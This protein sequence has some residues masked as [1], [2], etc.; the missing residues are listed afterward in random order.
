[1]NRA[2]ILAVMS[3]LKAAYPS[4]YR[5]MSRNEVENAINLWSDIFRFDDAGA[6]GMAVQDFISEDDKGFPPVPGQLKKRIPKQR[7]DQIDALSFSW[8]RQKEMLDKYEL[9]KQRR[10]E[11][12]IPATRFDAYKA[13]ILYKEYDRITEE[14]G[15]EDEEYIYGPERR[16]FPDVPGVRI[17]ADR[18]LDQNG[19]L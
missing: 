17:L 19:K 14:A 11:A 3:V 7:I 5:G 16:F 13:G 10:L 12:G 15:L 2:E 8:K 6:V 18:A 9:L 1:M 4:F